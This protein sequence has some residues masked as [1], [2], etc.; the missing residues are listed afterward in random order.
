MGK[1]KKSLLLEGK[2]TK[3][4]LMLQRDMPTVQNKIKRPQKCKKLRDSPEGIHGGKFRV[5]KLKVQLCNRGF[6]QLFI[7][8]DVTRSMIRYRKRLD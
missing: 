2:L 5:N 1:A 7:P 6:K 8:R 4:F 3:G